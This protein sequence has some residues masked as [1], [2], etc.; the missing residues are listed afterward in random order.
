MLK[1]HR[2]F[3]LIL[4]ALL[5]YLGTQSLSPVPILPEKRCLIAEGVVSDINADGHDI[6]ITLN[7]NSKRFYINRGL[8]KDLDVENLIEKLKGKKI[9][10][11]YPSYWTPLDPLSHTRHLSKVEYRDSVWYSELREDQNSFK[12]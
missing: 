5:L 9:N 12:H 6:F 1:N 8:D 7:D 11:K 2:W 3:V 4:L 10:L